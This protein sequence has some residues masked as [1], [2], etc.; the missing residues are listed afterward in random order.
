MQ[1]FIV[2]LPSR[3]DSNCISPVQSAFRRIACAGMAIIGISLA[4]CGGSSGAPFSPPVVAQQFSRAPGSFYAL[5]TGPQRPALD[6]IAATSHFGSSASVFT[7]SATMAGP[8]TGGAPNYYVLG[9]NRGGA[10]NAPFPGEPN[11]IFNA[12]VVVT[13][14]ADGTASSSVNLIPGG[15]TPLPASALTVSGATITVAV[16]AASLPSTGAALS[17][18]TWNLWP[19]SGLGGSASTQVASFAP[20]NGELPFLSSP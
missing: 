8:V 2:A 19:R 6:V 20:E 13:I 3:P 7:F 16:P 5:Y 10:T 4:G 17:A 14:A 11:V 15:A 9:L 1:P 18:Y 12:V